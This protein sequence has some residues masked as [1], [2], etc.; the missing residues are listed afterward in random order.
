MSPPITARA[1]GARIS[2]PA[3][4]ANASG[5]MPKIIA[6]VVITIGRRRVEPALTS[7]SLR[8]RPSRRAWFA[9]ST[10]RIAFLVTSPISMISPIMLMMFRL[11]PVASSAS[12]TPTSDSGSESMIANGCRNEPNWLAR[13]R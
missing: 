13:I 1:I 8:E 7:A 5:S 10:S 9:K 12:A 3:P 2:A 6:S 11:S 4:I